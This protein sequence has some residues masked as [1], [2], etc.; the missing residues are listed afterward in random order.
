MTVMGITKTTPKCR[1][2]R[3]RG[4]GLLLG[5]PLAAA[6][7]SASAPPVGASPFAAWPFRGND[8][9]DLEEVGVADAAAQLLSRAI[10][11]DTRNP[12]GNELPL[13]EY[14]VGFLRAQGIEARSIET[15]AGSAAEGRAAAWARLPGTGRR[16][17]VVLLSHL[18][19][20]P[21]APDEWAVDPYEGLVGGGY[22]V[23]R[24]ALD[25]KGVAIVQMLALVELSR[26]PTP[27]D[28]DVILL[29]TPD[30]EVGGK[31]GAGWLVRERREVL[32]DA[33][34]LLTEG[35][36]ILPGEGG[37]PD[38]WG[39]TFVEKSP[40][41]IEL[42][43]RGSPG[44]GSTT[45]ADAAVPR[46]VAALERLRKLETEVRVVPEVARMFSALSPYA[47]P[48]DR[49]AF[50]D[51][52]AALAAAPD[53]RERFLAEP[54]RNALVRDTVN[55]TMLRGS[56]RTNVVPA[57]ASARLDVRLL[58]DSRCGDFMER[59]RGVIAD[60][61][62]SVAPLLSFPTRSS[63]LDTPLYDA[64]R[65][66]AS[67]SRSHAVVVPRVI[68]GF[69]DAHYF[70]DLGIVAYGFVP[71]W[72][73]PHETRG[74]HGPNERISLDNLERGVRTLARI[75]EILGTSSSPTAAGGR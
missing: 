46:L 31:D 33:E 71:R 30:E 68:A 66:A 3:W 52:E 51:L 60:P 62:I 59:L 29:A 70:R 24:G 11:F 35:G 41:W 49:R 28:R 43:A 67:E 45:A 74:I 9:P 73:R 4:I 37:T 7:V 20:V 44:H 50:A 2:S 22:V 56:E 61:T 65:Q 75:L 57:A 48:E 55:I 32:R 15:P 14:L 64:I 21:A 63:P 27:L 69:T 58:P 26:R 16:R 17:P 39:V 36:G 34:F 12:P 72:L 23:G 1:I 38:I 54:G 8:Y 6:L 18:D 10:R 40:C 19:V 42:T 53:F 47:A 25:A 13:A 5:V